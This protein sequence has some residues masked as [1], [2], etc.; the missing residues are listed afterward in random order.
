MIQPTNEAETI[1]LFTLAGDL[2]GWRIVHLQERFPDAIIEN[3]RGQ[4]LTAEFEYCA[5]NFQQHGHNPRGC[6]LVICWCN[7][8]PD[9]TVPVWAL[10]DMILPDDPVW[11][12]FTLERVYHMAR[13]LTQWDMALTGLSRI[14]FEVRGIVKEALEQ[15]KGRDQELEDLRRK[16]HSL[17]LDI[18]CGPKKPY[19]WHRF[20]TVKAY[21]MHQDDYTALDV[22]LDS[23]Y[24]QIPE[25]RLFGEWWDFQIELINLSGESDAYLGF[26]MSHPAWTDKP[27]QGVTYPDWAL[28]VFYNGWPE[29]P[30]G[31]RAADTQ[32][33]ADP[34]TRTALA[35]IDGLGEL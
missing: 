26:D 33:E 24:K 7:L 35:A 17:E 6:D 15:D 11:D 23:L 14:P 5:R 4:R 18:K 8:W 13:S 28:D 25:A 34:L 9:A 10:E 21:T 31:E 19:G 3:S 2:L 29:T 27:S 12:R 16:V 32:Q 1:R 20:G 30:D 22:Y